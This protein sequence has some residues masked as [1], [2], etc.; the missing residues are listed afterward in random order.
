MIDI[1]QIPIQVLCLDKRKELWVELIESIRS[2]LGNDNIHPLVCGD[3]K[4]LPREEYDMIDDEKCMASYWGYSAV[5]HE[6]NHWNALRAHRIMLNKAKDN[7][8]PYFIFVEDDCY[9]LERFNKIWYV[10][11]EY[12][13]QDWDLV[14]PGYW[15]GCENDEWNLEIEREWEEEN[16]ASIIKWGKNLGGLH[17]TVVRDSMYDT[18]L[19]FK[20]VNP[21]DST[22]NQT[23]NKLDGTP[24]NRYIITPKITHVKTTWSY[25]EGSEIKRNKL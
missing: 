17:F 8:W 3:G 23:P 15:I 4:T 10:V 16:Q 12:I 25:C 1:T 7:K 2:K 18:I 21:I 9:I 20:E 19:N 5:G 6:V 22:L 24:I 11:E 13:P 14:Y